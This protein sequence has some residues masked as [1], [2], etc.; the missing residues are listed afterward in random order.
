MAEAFGRAVS[1]VYYK[2]RISSVTNTN[3]MP[4]ITHQQFANDTI[5]PG[6]SSVQEARIIKDIIKLYMEASRQKVNESK[7][8]IFFINMDP[9]LE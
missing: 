1:E 6:K 9:D 4:N 2:R 3:N 5:L 8:E 7:S